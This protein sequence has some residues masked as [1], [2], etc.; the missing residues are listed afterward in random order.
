[1]QHFSPA[2]TK[3]VALL[4]GLSLFLS[5]C[6]LS[7]GKFTSE[8]VLTGEDEFSFTY[9]GEIFFLGMSS[10]AK[11]SAQG[12][13]SAELRM[14]CFDEETFEERECTEAELAEQRAGSSLEM[15]QSAQQAQQLSAMMGGIDPSEPEAA[16]EL[17]KLLLRQK[18]WERVVDKGNGVFD[19]TYSVSGKLSHDFMFPLIEEFP[20]FNPFVQIF[21]REGSVVRINAPGFGPQDNDVPMM[22]NMGGMAGMAALGAESDQSSGSSAQIPDLP[23]LDGTFRIVTSGR[24]LAN[25]TDEGPT[26]AG[27]RESLEWDISPRTKDAPTALVDLSR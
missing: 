12:E 19:V 1:M 21:V 10:I 20:T 2:R 11:M 24:I 26:L 16:E 17:R 25:N 18:G 14:S 6:F 23:E 7:P 5:G 27:D 9:E 4:V 3:A 13:A 15:E 22:G 8:L